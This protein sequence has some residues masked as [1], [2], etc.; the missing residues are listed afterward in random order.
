MT[1]TRRQRQILDYLAAFISKHGYAP[2]LEEIAEKMGLGSLATVHEHLTN[3][4]RKGAIRRSH[5]ASRAIEVL[6]RMRQPGVAEVPLL[7]QVAAGQPIEAIESSDTMSLPEDMLPAAGSCFVLR[8]RGD[9]MIDE[10]IRDGDHIVVHGRQT[11]RNGETVVALVQGTHATVKRFYAEKHGR[12]RLQPAN[13]AMDP[14]LVDAADVQIQGVV[15]GVIR[16]Y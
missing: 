1:L 2:S 16:R 6:T 11:A 7:G 4:E 8:V 14:I 5:N 3:L 10:Q 9:S 13:T 12:V 15:V